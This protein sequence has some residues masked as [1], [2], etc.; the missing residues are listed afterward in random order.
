MDPYKADTENTSLTTV[1][2][3]LVGIHN[4]KKTSLAKKKIGQKKKPSRKHKKRRTKYFDPPYVLPQPSSPESK[5]MSS[6]TSQMETTTLIPDTP[7]DLSTT[8]KHVPKYITEPNKTEQTSEDI[9]DEVLLHII[10]FC[11]IILMHL[12]YFLK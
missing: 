8:S 2:Y 4:Q 3:C 5:G 1:C 6:N 7:I 9:A 12:T 10:I 11:K